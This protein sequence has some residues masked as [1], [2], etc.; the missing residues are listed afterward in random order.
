MSSSNLVIFDLDGTLARVNVSYAFAQFLHKKKILSLG[1]ML[2]LVGINL[3]HKCGLCSVEYVHQ[4]AFSTILAQK[5]AASMQQEIDLFLKETLPTL[6]RPYLLERLQEA[7]DA[8]ATIWLLSSSPECVVEPIAAHLG[9][10][11]CMAT[12]YEITN[13]IYTKVASIVTGQ[14]KRAFL[15]EFLVNSSLERSN[16]TAYSDSINDLPLLE[17][18]GTVIAVCPDSCLKKIARKRSWQVWEDDKV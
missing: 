14:T 4:F 13:G 2:T 15:E 3:A 18:V 6:F 10:T 9:I 11:T 16:I 17:A 5:Q 7:L 8:G 1:K 12:R